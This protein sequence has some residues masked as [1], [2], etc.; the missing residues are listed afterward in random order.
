MGLHFSSEI[1]KGIPDKIV[2]MTVFEANLKK[3]ME[4]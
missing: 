3:T 1:F 4:P 2:K